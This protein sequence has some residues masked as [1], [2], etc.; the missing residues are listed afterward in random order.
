MFEKVLFSGKKQSGFVS[1]SNRN[2][3]G[4]SKGA[5]LKMV[6]LESLLA[7]EERSEI[8]AK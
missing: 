5:F 6:P 2:K 4:T 7:K 3:K 1:S 8:V